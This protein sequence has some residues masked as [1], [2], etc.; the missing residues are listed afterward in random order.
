MGRNRKIYQ[1]VEFWLTLATILVTIIG[2]AA[3]ELR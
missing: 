3:L 2:Y 1:T